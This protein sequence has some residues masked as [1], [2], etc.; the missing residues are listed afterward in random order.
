MARMTRKDMLNTPDEFVTTTSSVLVWI[1]EHPQQFIIG[2]V[3]LVGI[4][5]GG[6]GIY[7]WKTSRELDAMNAYM[8]AADNSQATLQVAQDY[9]DT[10]AGKLAKLRLAR[11]SFDQGNQKMALSYADEFINK[12]GRKDVWHWQAVLIMASTYIQQKEPTKALPLLDGC[13]ENAP[14]DLT[15]QALFLKANALIALGK[16]NEARQSLSAISENNRDIAKI[17]IASLGTT[18]SAKLKVK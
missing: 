6:Y 12:W 15:D 2:V 1:R 16:D 14:K 9:S 7:Y 5:A 11:M 3:V 18:P 10:K 4:L 13:I 17:L 8:K